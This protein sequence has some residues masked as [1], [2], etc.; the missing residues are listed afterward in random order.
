[1]TFFYGKSFFA[2]MVLLFIKILVKTNDP[3]SI[4]YVDLAKFSFVNTNLAK[5]KECSFLLAASKTSR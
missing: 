5:K 1:M 3:L 4:I 2:L